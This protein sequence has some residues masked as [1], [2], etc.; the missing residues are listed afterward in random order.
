MGINPKETSDTATVQNVTMADLTP[1][2]RILVRSILKEIEAISKT[3]SVR[4]DLIYT[5][6]KKFF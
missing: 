5:V 4:H 6:A 2:E 3:G 1:H